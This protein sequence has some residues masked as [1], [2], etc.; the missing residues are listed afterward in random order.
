MRTTTLLT[1][2]GLAL[3]LGAGVAAAQAPTQGRAR[4]EQAQ[5]HRRGGRGPEAFLLKG[6]TL[7]AD[8]QARVADLQKQ[9]RSERPNEMR[10]HGQRGQQ[11]QPNAQGQRTQRTPADRAAMRERMQQRMQ[12]QASALRAILTPDQQR[13]FDAN[14][15]QMKQRFA[16]R[17]QNGGQRGNGQGWRHGAGSR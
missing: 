10:Q 14:L 8:Q 3:T 7:T 9:W 17:A 12:Q 16:N 5:G 1:S 11:G 13:T 4:A 2:L 15:A 6:I